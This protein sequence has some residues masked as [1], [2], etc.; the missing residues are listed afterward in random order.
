MQSAATSSHHPFWDCLGCWRPCPSL[1]QPMSSDWLILGMKNES[2]V[3]Q[4]SPSLCDP[5]DC[6][7][8]CSSVH[9]ILQARILEWVAISFSR[10]SS[11]P[12]DGTQVSCIV[13]ICFNLWATREAHNR[14]YYVFILQSQVL[15]DTHWLSL[16]LTEV[17]LYTI[18]NSTENTAHLVWPIDWVWFWTYHSL[19]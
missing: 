2:E 16:M 4:S 5:M 3:A 19:A 8:P 7:P 12:R 15:A 9:G 1:Q 13:V 17:L 11:W 10:G 18:S 6:S 14:H